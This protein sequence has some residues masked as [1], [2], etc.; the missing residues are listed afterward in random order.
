[1]KK[2]IP[3]ILAIAMLVAVPSLASAQ[4]V[5]KYNFASAQGNKHIQVTP[6]NQGTGVIYFY[7]IDGNRITHITLEVSQAPENWRVE[8]EP[9][10]H[11]ITVDI[12]GNIVTV[13]E[14]LHVEPYECLPQL[15]EDIPEGMVC[16][17][18]LNRGFALAKAANIIIQVPETADIG[19]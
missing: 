2:F 18:V 15:S 3:V 6:G 14:N 17:S 12:G 9:S 16:I 10:L 19:N 4:E 1:M 13:A 8:I 11:D 5:A 7:N